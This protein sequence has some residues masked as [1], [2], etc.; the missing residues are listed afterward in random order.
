MAAG[1]EA[2]QR[3]GP[4]GL[5]AGGAAAEPD[6]AAYR[7]AVTDVHA[8]L[9]GSGGLGL[10][11]AER[12]LARRLAEPEITAVL[13]A[14]PGGIDA[15]VERILREARNYRQSARSSAGNLAGLIRIALLAQIDVL[16]WGH[17]PAYQADAHVHAS[18]DLVDLRRLR[19][20][21]MLYFRYRLQASGLG[22]RAV[23]AVE[24]RVAADRAPRTAGLK[25][26]SARPELV[27][28]LNEIAAE[29]ASLAPRGT[30]RLWVT[31]LARSLDHQSHLRSLGYAALVPSAHC[32]GYAADVEMAWF[33]RFHADRTLQALLLERQSAGEVNV[34]DEGQAW[35]LCLCPGASRA[36]RLIPVQRSGD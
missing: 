6:V 5:L 7:R 20:D 22:G 35:H 26:A 36:L 4:D 28:L 2:G 29:F 12:I 8:E 17:L 21:G 27:L 30:P 14:I 18:T 32:V 34:I 1:W 24:R 3:A 10:V 19:R 31:S 23:R 13:A 11:T 9:G 33:R 15:A 25:F 16:W